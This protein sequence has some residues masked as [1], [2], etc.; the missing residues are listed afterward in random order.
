M[1]IEVGY[2]KTEQMELCFLFSQ[3]SK[4]H[5]KLCL[6]LVLLLLLLLGPQGSSPEPQK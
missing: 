5:F 3:F 6:L 2:H 1:D 4:P